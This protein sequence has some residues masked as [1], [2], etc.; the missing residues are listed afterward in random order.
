LRGN[1]RILNGNGRA[2]AI[3]PLLGDESVLGFVH[4]LLAVSAANLLKLVGHAVLL[5][6]EMDRRQVVLMLPFPRW[7]MLVRPS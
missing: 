6:Q 3:L 1:R 2:E 5:L 7:L 4:E